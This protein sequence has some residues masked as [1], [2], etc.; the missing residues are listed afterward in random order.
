MASIRTLGPKVSFLPTVNCHLAF[1]LSIISVRS[2]LDSLLFVLVRLKTF[3][4]G[5]VTVLHCVHLL[6]VP[7]GGHL[8]LKPTFSLL[9]NLKITSATAA[10]LVLPGAAC[11][12]H[13][14]H[15][16]HRHQL[17][18]NFRLPLSFGLLKNYYIKNVVLFEENSILL[19]PERLESS[20]CPSSTIHST[21]A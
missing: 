11:H 10:V 20:E 12:H 8:W 7:R 2:S 17:I 14:H 3:G 4:V 5:L 16:H 19:P 21:L 18:T 13:H 15:R 6:D 9:L 1:A